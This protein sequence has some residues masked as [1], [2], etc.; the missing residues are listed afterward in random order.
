MLSRVSNLTS[1]LKPPPG[2]IVASSGDVAD[3]GD[4]HVPARGGLRPRAFRRVRE[5]ILA[6]L[7]ENISNSV[8]AEFVGLSAS[9]FVRAFKQSAGLSPHRFVLQ[10]RVDRVKRLLIETELPLAQIALTAGF[11]DQAHCTRWFRE[12]VGIPPGRFRWSRR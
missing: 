7:E 12:L 3:G 9:Y 4:V 5:Y 10:S 2:M 8:L 1:Q 11:A 6:H